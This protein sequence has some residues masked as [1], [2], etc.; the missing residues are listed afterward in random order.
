MK[1]RPVV[2][3]S[4]AR[5]QVDHGKL[6]TSAHWVSSEIVAAVSD[7]GGS[8]YVLPVSAS[9]TAV[10]AAAARADALVLTGGHDVST[11]GMPPRCGNSDMTRDASDLM[12]L[13]IARSRQVPVLG[14]CR[15][16]QLL[17]ASANGRLHP[18]ERHG[19]GSITSTHRHW[20]IPVTGSR[21]ASIV[22]DEP[23]STN[24]LHQYAVADAG[25]HE[26]GA[27]A[28]D[29]VVEAVEHP[30]RWEMGVQWH[31]ELDFGVASQRL[32]RAL[33][34]A[35]SDYSQPLREEVPA[36]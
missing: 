27:Y 5:G 13:R 36:R 34:E 4:A 9:S 28:E 7:H 18:V 11:I 17:V 30:M 19:T 31:P 21:L 22:G 20:V 29:G 26:P 6:T 35:A 3:I 12:L 10:A 23:F 2:A 14:I 32:W 15:G 24:S 16:M 8:P 1:I 33:V 25:S